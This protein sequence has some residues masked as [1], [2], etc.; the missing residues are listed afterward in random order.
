MEEHH[1]LT[2]V[3][4]TEG[5]IRSLMRELFT[6]IDI[7]VYTEMEKDDSLYVLAAG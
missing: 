5:S 1:G 2:F 3:Y 7:V 6:V 4:Q